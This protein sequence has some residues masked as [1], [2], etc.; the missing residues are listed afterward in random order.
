MNE[1]SRMRRTVTSSVNEISTDQLGNSV[2]VRVGCV[3]IE[4]WR[5]FSNA[6][7]LY[8]RPKLYLETVSFI[9]SLISKEESF[10][11]EIKGIKHQLL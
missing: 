2:M 9:S 10:L 1:T 5:I 4:L 8:A 6:Y 3:Y 11:F 7:H